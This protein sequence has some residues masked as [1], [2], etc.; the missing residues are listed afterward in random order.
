MI[1]KY[2]QPFVFYHC[3]PSQETW[4]IFQLTLNCEQPSCIHLRKA[5]T[6]QQSFRHH[7]S[8]TMLYTPSIS[9]CYYFL[10]LF[11]SVL[12]ST[13]STYVS[14]CHGQNV[15]QQVYMAQ[16]VQQTLYQSRHVKIYCMWFLSTTIMFYK[17][18]DLLTGILFLDIFP[19][20]HN[21]RSSHLNESDMQCMPEIGRQS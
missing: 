15:T 2:W 9:P 8:L 14:Q 16:T 6:A 10:F 11:F 5:E 13:A 21:R 19:T 1:K 4:E 17:Q 7:T 3:Y 12:L 20:N 18:K